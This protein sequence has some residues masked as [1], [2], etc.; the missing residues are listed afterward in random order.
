MAS[1]KKTSSIENRKAKTKII[2]LKAYGSV[3]G[4]GNGVA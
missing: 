1:A 3:S 4:S 2:I